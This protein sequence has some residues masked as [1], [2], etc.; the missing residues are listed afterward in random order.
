VTGWRLVGDVGGTNARFARATGTVINDRRT[1]SV[2]EFVTFYDALRRYLADTGGVEGCTSAAIGVAGLVEDGYVKLTNAAWIIDARETR[3]LLGGLPTEL[4][5]D[6]QAVAAGLP[7]LADKDLTHLGAARPEGARRTMLALNVG[8][9]FGAAAAVPSADGWTNCGC[10]P[11]HMSLGA[12]NADELSVIEGFA[13][14]EH[15][16]S[17]RG[18]QALYSRLATRSGV[19][20]GGVRSGAEIFANA[21]SDAIAAETVHYFSRLLGRVAGDLALATGA[22]GGVYLCGSVV[23]GWEAVAD[24]GEFREAF[25]AKGVMTDRMRSIYTGVIEMEDIPLFGLTHLEVGA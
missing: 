21:G 22:W 11:G 19:N 7:H 20:L 9:G 6:L 18:V 8:T 10:E 3:R 12:L 5:N 23:Q 2:P 15:L 17:G 14:V 16:L 13:S 25:E 1:Y 24:T 4:V